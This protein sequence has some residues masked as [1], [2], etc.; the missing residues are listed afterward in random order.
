MKTIGIT[1]GFDFDANYYF[2]GYPRMMLNEDYSRSVIASGAIPFIIPIHDNYD[3]VYQ[4]VS[5]VD[6]ILLSGG[7]DVHPRLYQQQPNQK[8]GAV[9]RERDTFEYL[10]I[11]A[12][13]ALNKPIFGICRG[14][15][16]LNVYFGGTLFQDNGIKGEVFQHVQDGNPTLTMHTVIIE[17]DSFV[18]NALNKKELEVN[19]FHHQSIDQIAPTMKVVARALDGIVEAIQH[20]ELPIFAVQWHPEMLSRENEEARKLFEYFIN[21]VKGCSHE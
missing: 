7:Q 1:S 21:S 14:S 2:K 18:F 16:V 20:K 19:S 4:Q 10:V 9:S 13:L 11:K 3:V 6:G 12:A 5:R 15:Q 8:L 17:E